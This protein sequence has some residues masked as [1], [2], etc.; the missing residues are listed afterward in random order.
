MKTIV[1]GGS[2]FIGSHV[3]DILSGRGHEVIIFDIKPSAYLKPD[4]EMVVGDI[5]D[6]EGVKRAVKGCDYV[7]NFAGIA[8]LDNAATKPVETVRQNITGA[9]N[10]LEACKEAKVKR[11]V[12]AS[13]IYVHSQQGGFY[14]CSKQAAELY[15]EEYWERY[16]LGYNILRYG[17]VYGL[18]ADSGNS[19]FRYLDQ[20]LREKKVSCSGSGEE[21]REYINVK[22]AAALSVDILTRE[23]KNQHITITGHRSMTLRD[24]LNNVNDVLNGSVKVMY[25][26]EKRS[27]HHYVITPYSYQPREGRKLTGNCYIDLSQGL[28]ECI[29]EMSVKA[30]L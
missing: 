5:L 26:P 4:Q 13:T 18:R 30:K 11:F 27:P 21:I 24:F 28:L 25:E 19:I 29:Q 8:N 9:V 16:G 15:I 17:T 3:A 20:A 7:Y 14:R 23:Y 1:F 10:I 6:F 2:G 12:Y 22:D